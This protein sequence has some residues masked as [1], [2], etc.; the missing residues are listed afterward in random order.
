MTKSQKPS[1]KVYVVED[2]GEGDDAAGFWT[3]KGSTLCSP[4]CP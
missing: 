4:R 2:R 1:Y 3:A